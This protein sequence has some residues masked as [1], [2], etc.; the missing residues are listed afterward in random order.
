[1]P[2][3]LKNSL[4]PFAKAIVILIIG[5]ILIKVITK[6]LAKILQ[7]SK[8]ESM[9]HSF[10]THTVQIGLWIIVILS[11]LG[12]LGINTTSVVTVLAACGAAVALALQGSLSN[13]AGG[14]LVLVTRPFSDGD[15]IAVAGN[16]G[17]VQAMDLL[18]TTIL[19]VDGKTIM[20]PNSSITNGTVTNFTKSGMR[21]V[22]IQIG[23]SYNSDIEIALNT[24]ISMAKEEPTV[25][26]DPQPVCFVIDYA[27]SAV[28]LELRSYCK[29]ADYW[30][31]R[32]A[33]TEKM[34]SVL[35]QAGI[36]IP[37]PQMDVH[38]DK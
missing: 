29:S 23:I 34:K 4:F 28:I 16:E 26:Q 13:L 12:T 1:M 11:V 10:V 22:D 33:M 35:T 36:E 8:I 37:F 25:L 17:T 19:T 2:E 14:I 9:L 20:I 6:G 7:K 3:L 5:F 31:T 24:L 32:F 30:G 15:Y 21:R 38:L 27:D 18:Y